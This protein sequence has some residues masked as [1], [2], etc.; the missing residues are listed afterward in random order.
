MDDTTFR[1]LGARAGAQWQVNKTH[2]DLTR[3]ARPVRPL[4]L[5]AQPQTLSIDLG[6]TAM[7][8]IDM[9]NDFCAKGGWLDHIGVDYTPARKPIAPLQRVGTPP[10]SIVRSARRT[11]SG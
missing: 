11:A 6:K 10:A 9:Q 5:A 1:P 3:P 8:V 2:A 7:I 4:S